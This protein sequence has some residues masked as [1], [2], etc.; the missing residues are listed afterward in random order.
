MLDASAAGLGGCPFA[1]GASGNIPTEE[2]VYLLESSGIHTGV[3]LSAALDAARLAEQ[4][5]GHPAGSHLLRAGST[6]AKG[7]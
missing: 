1:P 2:L 4:L 7:H 3:D 6:S 5:V